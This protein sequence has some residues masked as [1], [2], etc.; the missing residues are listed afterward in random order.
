MSNRDLIAELKI[1]ESS[2]LNDVDPY[3]SKVVREAV[4]ALE[5]HEWQPIETAPQSGKKID[6]WVYW[7]EN[8]S[9]RRTT[10]AFWNNKKLGWQLGKFNVEDFV[11][12]PIVTHWKHIHPPQPGD[13]DDE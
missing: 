11:Y 13:K 12:K 5:A 9:A 3:V 1:V 7:P 6:V 8:K 2:Y 4:D 10:D